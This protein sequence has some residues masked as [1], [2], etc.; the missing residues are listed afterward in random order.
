MAVATSVALQLEAAMKHARPTARDAGDSAPDAGDCARDAGDL[1]PDAGDAAP[2]THACTGRHRIARRAALRSLG[3]A[4]L[5]VAPAARAADALACA[6]RPPQTEGPF[7]VDEPL[8]R[9]DIRPD[10]ATGTMAE[11]A[12]LALALAVARLAYGG[13]APL[14]GARVSLWQCDAAGRYSDVRGLPQSTVGQRFLRGYQASDAQGIARFVTIVPGWYPGRAVHIHFRIDAPAGSGVARTF[15]SQLYFDDAFV[16]AVHRRDP[17]RQRQGARVRNGD[18]GLF[19]RG[20]RDLLL[21]PDAAGEGYAA[22]LDVA[23]R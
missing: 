6:L 3:L 1:A 16:D 11:G 2:D 15:V 10:P 20:G 19:R 21:A 8:A 17:Y 9:S 23:L 5:A 12:P 14:P 13:C 18:D 7:Y 22:R 4:A